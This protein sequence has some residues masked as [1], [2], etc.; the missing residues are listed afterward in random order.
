MIEKL[1]GLF[2]T[3]KRAGVSLLCIGIILVTIGACIVVY[4]AGQ[5]ERSD[6]IGTENAQNFAFADAGVDPVE[7]KTVQV[8]FE[9]FQ[10]Q[11]VYDVEFI[12]GDTEYE[13]KINADD[14]SVVKKESKTIKS[15][16]E[17][18]PLSGTIT[19]EDAREIAL[20]D[21][22]LTREQA[23]FTEAEQ[24]REDGISVYEFKF[25][26]GN[27]AY[28][29]EI[30]AQT[31]AVYSKSMVT[32][33]GSGSGAATSTTPPVNSS[34]PQQSS[35]P[36]QSAPPAQA[37]RPPAASTAP[38]PSSGLTPPTNPITPPSP[39]IS[40]PQQS[41]SQSRIPLDEAKSA[42]LTD[43]GA[44]ASDVQYTKAELD[45]EDGL[46]V[47]EIKFYTATHK[48]EYEINAATGAVYSKSVE[49]F[50][51]SGGHHDDPHHSAS[52]TLIGSDQARSAC[53]NH[54]GCTTDQ[55]TFTKVE[56]DSE[57]GLTV[58]EVEFRRD[59]IKYE[60]TVDAITGD[61]LEYEWDH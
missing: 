39:P 27:V 51:N 8:K 58:Y 18:S 42:A 5:P 49:A 32:Y 34:T 4:A 9:R 57:D 3:K 17:T 59:G 20:S 26:A 25:Y 24:D 47:Y 16:E 7:A 61:I 29:Y 54:A 55:V 30:N 33:M 10:G 38:Q 50:S 21:A 48:Y 13:Y 14:G 60:Y 6:A 56:L 2:S 23:T 44:S 45:R 12:A 22:G 37:S 41:G 19:L 46:W 28:D 36:V 15:P 11:F 43:A 40:Q 35:S 53:L 1:K 31:G 52:G